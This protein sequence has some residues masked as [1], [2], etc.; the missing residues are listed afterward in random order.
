MPKHEE[1]RY[2][3][4]PRSGLSSPVTVEGDRGDVVSHRGE[5]LG[6]DVHGLANGN[7]GPSRDEHAHSTPR[8][9]NAPARPRPRPARRRHSL[10]FRTP[11]EAGLGSHDSAH[12]SILI[13]GNPLDLNTGTGEENPHRKIRTP[14]APRLVVL[15]QRM[16][17]SLAR[18]DD[19]SLRRERGRAVNAL[20]FSAGP[21]RTKVVTRLN[22]QEVVSPQPMSLL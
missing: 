13:R 12:R 15:D 20:V 7:D 16:G 3:D 11:Q 19:A 17:R 4:W 8:G 10:A 14:D 5:V 1:D 2:L 22:S 18:D 6:L 21:C 9:E